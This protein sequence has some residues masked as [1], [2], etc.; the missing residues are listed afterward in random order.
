MA[1]SEIPAP[2]SYDASP[3]LKFSWGSVHVKEAT[4]IIGFFGVIL[5]TF[6]LPG[7]L[8]TTKLDLFWG[9][10]GICFFFFNVFVF[11]FLFI[12]LKRE[13]SGFLLPYL[14]YQV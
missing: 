5:S 13:K 11:T 10:S 14:I 3:D 8:F 9:I 12:G 7:L 1:R 2:P 4:Q 6:F